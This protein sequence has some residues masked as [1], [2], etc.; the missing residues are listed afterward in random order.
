LEPLKSPEDYVGYGR[1]QGFASPGGQVLDKPHTYERPARLR[2]N[3]WGFL[4]D[5]T[6]TKEPARLNRA[7]GS[8]VYRFHARDLNL[9]MGPSAPETSVKFRVT[10]DGQAPGPAHGTDVDEQG[11]GTLSM[12]HTYQLI[13]QPMPIADREFQIE[14]FSPGV[15]TFDFTFG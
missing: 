1:S 7:N 4:G 8:I 2:L 6:V 3:E 14:F 9:V 11:N 5:W 12:Q 13:R 15:E 10:I